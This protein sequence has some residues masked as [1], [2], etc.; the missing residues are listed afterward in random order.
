MT[1]RR[2]SKKADLIS[3]PTKRSSPACPN[4]NAG[5][6]AAFLRPGEAF[7]QSDAPMVSQYP[8]NP[9]YYRMIQSS[10]GPHLM[11]RP[12]TVAAAIIRG[13]SSLAA[14]QP[15]A[16]VARQSPYGKRPLR[17]THMPALD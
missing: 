8:R 16:A 9:R 5:F 17:D 2:A 7:P 12:F 13:P 1:P 15:Y 11:L 6:R 3:S 4:W 14:L 10:T